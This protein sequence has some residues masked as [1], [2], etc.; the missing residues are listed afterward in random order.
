MRDVQLLIRYVWLWKNE[1]HP[2][3]DDPGLSVYHTVEGEL[4]PGKSKPITYQPSPPLPARAD[5]YFEAI[6]SVAGFTE[7]IPPK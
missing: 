6:V 3:E 7:I 1:F 5:G 2:G 4:P